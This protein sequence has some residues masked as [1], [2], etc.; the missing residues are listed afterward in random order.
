MPLETVKKHSRGK[1]GSDDIFRVVM[2]LNTVKMTVLDPSLCVGGEKH[3]AKS[4]YEET[5]VNF[6]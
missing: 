4:L 3:Y 1:N 6:Y 2:K 5:G